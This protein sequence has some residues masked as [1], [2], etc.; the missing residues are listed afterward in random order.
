[1][2]NAF[3]TSLLLSSGMH[4]ETRSEEMAS[5]FAF[6][7]P[8]CNVV[9]WLSK[10][11]C[12]PLRDF[13]LPPRSYLSMAVCRWQLRA[14]EQTFQMCSPPPFHKFGLLLTFHDNAIHNERS[15]CWLSKICFPSLPHLVICSYTCHDGKGS[16]KPSGLQQLLTDSFLERAILVIY[17][18]SAALF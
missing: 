3:Y 13:F 2:M 18:L 8:I 11:V 14:I 10:H 4:G 9:A 1:M 7:R 17:C 6:S 16:T 12:F 15:I 5:S